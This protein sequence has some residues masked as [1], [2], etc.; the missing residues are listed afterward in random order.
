MRDYNLH[1]N[2]NAWM[3]E[4][5]NYPKCP[6]VA[7]GHNFGFGV[8]LDL[9]DKLVYD[10]HFKYAAHKIGYICSMELF[11]MVPLVL[12]CKIFYCITFDK[13]F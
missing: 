2:T 5:I 12:F 10:M 6:Q 3:A 13:E 4:N 7:C 8:D 9:H 11:S 1:A